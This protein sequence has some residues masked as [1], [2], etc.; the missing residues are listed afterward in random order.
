[1]SILIRSR[2]PTPNRRR[3]LAANVKPEKSGTGTIHRRTGSDNVATSSFL[4]E[5]DVIEQGASCGAQ[6]R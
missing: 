3:H 1:M 4:G 5:R 6:N 2:R